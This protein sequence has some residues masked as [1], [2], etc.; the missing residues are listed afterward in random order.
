MSCTFENRPNYTG[1]NTR[2]E[3]FSEGRKVQNFE[4]SNPASL[5]VF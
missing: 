4:P 5:E 2:G 3:S 1:K